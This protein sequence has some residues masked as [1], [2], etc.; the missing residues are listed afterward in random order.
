M[1]AKKKILFLTR[2]SRMGASSRLRTYQYLPLF[3]NSG[4]EWTIKPLFND[5]YLAELY[6][7]KGV[8]FLNIF[9]CYFNRFLL[10]FAL[11]DYERIL[12]EK[13][14]FPFFPSWAEY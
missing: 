7:G 3:E 11:K 8:S 4:Y 13:E 2:Y 14:L 1:N 12:I 9:S 10:L 5:Q 6:S